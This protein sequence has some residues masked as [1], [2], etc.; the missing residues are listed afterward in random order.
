MIPSSWKPGLLTVHR[1]GCG[2]YRVQDPTGYRVAIMY[3][4]HDE[5][6]RAVADNAADYP[7]VVA[8][9]AQVAAERDRM[10]DALGRVLETFNKTHPAFRTAE[11]RAAAAHARDAL[12]GPGV[13]DGLSDADLAAALDRIENAPAGDDPLTDAVLA[14]LADGGTRALDREWEMGEAGA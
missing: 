3:G 11:L 5:S 13:L 6:V 12:R 10:A 9:L 2:H 14:D 1:T 4:S 8:E 7:R